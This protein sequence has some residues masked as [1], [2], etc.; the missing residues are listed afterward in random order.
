VTQLFQCPSCNAPLEYDGVKNIVGCPYCGNNVIVPES[1]RPRQSEPKHSSRD[2]DRLGTPFPKR[3]ILNV[4]QTVQQLTRNGQKIAAIRLFR[5]AFGVTLAEAR[6]AVETLEAGNTIN[7]PP[8]AAPFGRVYKQNP[9]QVL[10]SYEER[11]GG[12]CWRAIVWLV[13]LG[14]ILL[15]IL[16]FAVPNFVYRQFTT[17]LPA[18]FTEV[19]EQIEIPLL[20]TPTPTPGF[21]TPLGQFGS[22]GVG[23]GRFS[24]ARGIALRNDGRIYV[25]EYSTGRIQV[26][27]EDGSFLTQWTIPSAPYISAVAVDR[28]GILVAPIGG[29]LQQFAANNGQPFGPLAISEAERAEDTIH[30]LPDG[31]WLVVLDED[32]VRLN[33]AGDEVLRIPDAFENATGTSE[34]LPIVAADG[35]GN[36]YALGRFA[37]LVLKFD[38]EGRYITRFGGRS[39]GG[40]NTPGTLNAPQSIAVDGKGRVLVGDIFGI[41]VFD[42][43]GRFQSVIDTESF[44]F[45]IAV[46]DDDRI[47]TIERDHVGIYRLN[48]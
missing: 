31:G 20:P 5:D 3:D 18:I 44:P 30:A 10:H 9:Q 14:S 6:T 42:S 39:E 37:N 48:K 22:E 16:A 24:D 38:A 11:G 4:L 36:I 23:P 19:Q 35:L 26:F 8:I 33:G 25:S 12:G 46:H 34:M 41:Q 17:E 13:I 21:A 2:D 40:A 29:K 43:D 7:P 15:A 47:F 27:D 1:L 28:A 45:G 32:I